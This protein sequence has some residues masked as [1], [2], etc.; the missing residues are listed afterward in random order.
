MITVRT[1]VVRAHGAVAEP[2]DVVQRQRRADA[3]DAAR[4]RSSSSAPDSCGD[5]DT[6]RRPAARADSRP[7]CE[8]SI[9]TQSAAASA[10][11]DAAASSANGAQVGVR[12]RL[13]GR[14][15]LG[16]DDG[17]EAVASDPARVEDAPDLGAA[18]RPTRWR[19]ARA[20]AARRIASAAPGKSTD[21]S[22]S[23]ASS[24]TALR[25]TSAA[26]LRR[27]PRAPAVARHRLETR[28]TSS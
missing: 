9:A 8:S 24:R 15:V 6:V 3:D 7:H 12:R 22:R 16:G 2:V 10:A 19:S 27:R 1:A 18:A 13:A 26:T 23:S 4:R 11:A 14:R 20:A 25:A 5:A 28:P 17:G 21:A